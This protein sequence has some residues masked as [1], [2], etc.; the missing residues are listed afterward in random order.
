MVKKA[1]VIKPVKVLPEV[2]IEQ[3]V[4]MPTIPP[5]VE[6]EIKFGGV[7]IGQKAELPDVEEIAGESIAKRQYRALIE[8]YKKSSPYKYEARKAEFDE[9]LESLK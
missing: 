8:A 3:P 9:R 7:T 2:K 1:K 4:A 5:K 6:T